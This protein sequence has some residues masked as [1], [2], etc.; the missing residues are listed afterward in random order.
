MTIN[1]FFRK[2]ISC[3]KKSSGTKKK[4][5]YIIGMSKEDFGS[6]KIYDPDSNE[7]DPNEIEF[8]DKDY[9]CIA[10]DL[11]PEISSRRDNIEPESEQENPFIIVGRMMAALSRPLPEKQPNETREEFWERCKRH[12]A[13]S[14]EIIAGEEPAKI[15][16]LLEKKKEM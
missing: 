1:S 14:G 11:N 3:L 6:G 13:V 12:A 7:I 4:R 15:R 9:G 5:K 8:N 10:I 2:L 16:E